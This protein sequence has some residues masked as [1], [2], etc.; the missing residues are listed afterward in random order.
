MVVELPDFLIRQARKDDLPALVA[1]FAA[2]A[3]GGHGDTTDPEA[4]QDYLGAFAVIE[5]SPDQTLY[6]AECGGEVVGTFQTMVTTSLTG[7]GSSGMIIEAVQTRAD[8]RGQGIGAAM[9]E[10]AIAEAKGRGVRLVQL[11]SNALRKDAHRF[12][13]R[14]GFKPSHLGFKMALK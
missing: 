13:E 5:A 3:V 4:I 10:F 14:L 6:V 7:R 1:I 2:D 11:T 12:Y 8:R 9:I